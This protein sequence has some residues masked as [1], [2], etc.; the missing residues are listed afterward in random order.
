[1]SRDEKA[2]LEEDL[3]R[4]QDQAGFREWSGK[5]LWVKTNGIPFRGRYTTHFRA[6]FLTGLRFFTNLLCLWMVVSLEPQSK[7]G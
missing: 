2:L 1:M 3:R 7:P 4:A 6:A 5:W